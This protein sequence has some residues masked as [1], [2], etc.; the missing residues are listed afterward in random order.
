MEVKI[1]NL[2]ET[3][4]LA[5]C[6]ADNIKEKGAFVSLFG[7]IGAGKTAFT[8]FLLKNLGVIE[9][10]TSPSFV[11]L[12]EYKTKFFPIYHFDLYRLENEGVKSIKD[13]LLAY[14]EDKVLTLV[15]WAN[16]GEGELP[17]DKIEINIKYDLEKYSQERIFE[18]NA[19]GE[20]F[21]NVVLKTV[22]EFNKKR[23]K[24]WNF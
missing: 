6:F 12:N 20:Y 5:E 9:D 8:R 17:I 2:D 1:K 4:L 16:F 22:E 11:I 18:M 14:S 24:N 13:E 10:V 23:N 15:E 3:K 19:K 21:E 7:D